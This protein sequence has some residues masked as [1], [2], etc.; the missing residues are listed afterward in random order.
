[1]VCSWVVERRRELTTYCKHC[2][3]TC[4]AVASGVALSC[5]GKDCDRLCTLS[6]MYCQTLAQKLFSFGAANCGVATTTK[7]LSLQIIPSVLLVWC[8]WLYFWRT[9]NTYIWK[10]NNLSKHKASCPTKKC[11]NLDQFSSI[12]STHTALMNGKQGRTE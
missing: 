10:R 11:Y 3:S 12:C 7:A 5:L 6:T 1:M 2:T 4:Q 8:F 9:T